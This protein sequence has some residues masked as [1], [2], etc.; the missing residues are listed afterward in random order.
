[1]GSTAVFVRIMGEIA[2]EKGLFGTCWHVLFKLM[3]CQ[4]ADSKNDDN[5]NNNYLVPI[6]AEKGSMTIYLYKLI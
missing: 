2:P 3:Y 1:M 6:P 4:S 5:N